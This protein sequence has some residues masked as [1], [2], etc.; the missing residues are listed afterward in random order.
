MRIAVIAL[1]L[2]Q[3]SWRSI[4]GAAFMAQQFTTQ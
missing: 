1:S 3:H 2:A 4:H